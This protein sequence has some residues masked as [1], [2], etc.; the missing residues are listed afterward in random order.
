[1]VSHHHHG[2]EICYN[3][4]HCHESGCSHGEV[5]GGTC[6]Q[7]DHSG[8]EKGCVLRQVSFLPVKQ[9]TTGVELVPVK[10][11]VAVFPFA[12]VPDLE[13]PDPA[14]ALQKWKPRSGAPPQPPLL[15]Y[16]PCGLRAPPVV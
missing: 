3:S 5:Q 14:E 6:H 13:N 10:K 1:M 16:N 9:I 12:L 7:N 11:A 8:N 15:L 2:T 4:H